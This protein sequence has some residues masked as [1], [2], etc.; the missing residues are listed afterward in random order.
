MATLAESSGM[1]PA[2]IVL[3]VSDAFSRVARAGTGTRN[4][5]IRNN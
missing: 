4:I 3:L 2:V 1:D 5:L